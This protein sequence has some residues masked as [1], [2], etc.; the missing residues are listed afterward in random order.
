MIEGINPEEL[1]KYNQLLAQD[2]MPEEIGPELVPLEYLPTVNLKEEL[3]KVVDPVRLEEA[4]KAF[5]KLH[6]QIQ[7]DIISDIQKRGEEAKDEDDLWDIFNRLNLLIQQGKEL[8]KMKASDSD[9]NQPRPKPSSEESQ[10]PRK[11]E[12]VKE[13]D[14]WVKEMERLRNRDNFTPKGVDYYKH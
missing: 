9:K 10:L 12:I 1:K 13:I 11:K 2:G 7:Q 14:R 3:L 6:G 4:F 8:Q 5:S